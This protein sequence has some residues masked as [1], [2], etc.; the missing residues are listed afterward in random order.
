[1]VKE[2]KVLKKKQKNIVKHVANMYITTVAIV[3]K[4]HLNDFG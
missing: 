4:N 2:L 3:P 1:M